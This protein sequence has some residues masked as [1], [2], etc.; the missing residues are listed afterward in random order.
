MLKK[1]VCSSNDLSI[2]FCSSQHIPICNFSDLKPIIGY[3]SPLNIH[4]AFFVRYRKTQGEKNSSSEKTF[5]VFSP[6][7][8]AT[9][10]FQAIFS[11]LTVPKYEKLN[12][13]TSFGSKVA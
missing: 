1:Y 2:D 10:G 5:G 13:K 6:K 9:G 12:E 7:T 3:V 11:K 4:R 8:Q